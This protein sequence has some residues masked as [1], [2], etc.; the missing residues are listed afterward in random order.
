[1][2]SK[3]H[4][5]ILRY[6]NNNPAIILNQYTQGMKVQ[7]KKAFIESCQLLQFCHLLNVVGEGGGGRGALDKL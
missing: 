5:L 2:N 3:S 6:N 4:V 1:M 7:L